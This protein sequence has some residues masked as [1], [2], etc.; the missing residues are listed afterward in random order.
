VTAPTLPSG[1]YA[2]SGEEFLNAFRESNGRD[3]ESVA[4]FG[5]EAGEA[6]MDSIRNGLRGD[7]ASEAISTLRKSTR[8]AFFSISERPSA[9]GSYSIDADGDTSLTF[10]G[11]YR[12]ENGELVLGRAIDVP[13]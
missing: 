7:I 9:L 4:I 3:A 11:A 10:Y 5:Y 13:P 1:N 2:L 8:D 6:V 12:V